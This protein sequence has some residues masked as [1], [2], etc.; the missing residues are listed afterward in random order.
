M[1]RLPADFASR[2]VTADR[3]E[4]RREDL[5]HRGVAREDDYPRH[6]PF[7]HRREPAEG[8]S[9]MRLGVMLVYWAA[10]LNLIGMGVRL[11][12]IPIAFGGAVEAVALI[13]LL[14]IGLTLIGGVLGLVGFIMFCTIPYQSGARGWAMAGLACMLACIA[15]IVLLFIRYPE[16]SE[17]I[18][19]AWAAGI[20]LLAFLSHLFLTLVLRAAARYWSDTALGDSF[21]SYLIVSWVGAVVVVGTFIYMIGAAFGDPLVGRRGEAGFSILL[22]CGSLVFSVAMM[23][24]YLV[25]LNRL[26]ERIPAR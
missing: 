26:R 5:G 3:P 4:A 8:W 10:L 20:L 14:G 1:K 6:E 21:V 9:G 2:A 15:A 13:Q 19:L 18:L 16:V 25:L 11:L 24:W 23:I 12:G 7:Y 22:G 17:T